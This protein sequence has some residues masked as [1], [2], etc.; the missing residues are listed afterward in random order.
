MSTSLQSNIPIDDEGIKQKYMDSKSCYTCGSR[1]SFKIHMQS[2]PGG[3]AEYMY[4][5][6]SDCNRTLS[7]TKI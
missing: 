5:G 6:C 1:N 3:R 2:R 7:V 4:L